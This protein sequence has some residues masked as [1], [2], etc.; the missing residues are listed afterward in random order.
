MGHRR[1]QITRCRGRF[2]HVNSPFFHTN[3]PAVIHSQGKPKKYP[4]PAFPIVSQSLFSLP[5]IDN[6]QSY[7]LS[8]PAECI[9]LSDSPSFFSSLFKCCDLVLHTRAFSSNQ[10]SY[11]DLHPNSVK[12]LGSSWLS[13][14]HPVSF[15]GRNTFFTGI[16]STF[17]QGR[18]RET[19]ILAHSSWNQRSIWDLDCTHV[20]LYICKLVFHPN[21]LDRLLFSRSLYHT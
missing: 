13:R 16:H 3:N 11:M 2:I 4:S 19:P 20:I 8:S 6:R 14:P 15:A 5:P 21:G 7:I 17:L 10:I 1:A 18:S 12:H 9:P